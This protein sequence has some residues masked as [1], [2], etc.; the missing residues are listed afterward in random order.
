[1]LVAPAVLVPKEN[2]ADFFSLATVDGWAAPEGWSHVAY[3]LAPV[4]EN[5][6]WVG[7]SEITLGRGGDVVLIVLW[8]LPVMPPGH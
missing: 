4:P 8:A 7:L 2:P 1:M 6:S 5:A 3:E